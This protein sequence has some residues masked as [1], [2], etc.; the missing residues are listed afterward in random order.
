MD[1]P[2]Y[3][4]QIVATRGGVEFFRKQYEDYQEGVSYILLIEA[5]SLRERGYQ[6]VSTEWNRIVLQSRKGE[7][8]ILTLSRIE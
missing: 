8:I 1:K 4:S 2:V 6:F 3:H 5:R 7:Q